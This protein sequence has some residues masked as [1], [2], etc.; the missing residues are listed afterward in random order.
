MD[1]G[2]LAWVG[3][4]AMDGDAQAWVGEEVWAGDAEAWVGEEVWAVWAGEVDFAAEIS[5]K[6]RT[7]QILSATFFNMCGRSDYRYRAHRHGV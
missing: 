3:E 6:W 4:E 1:G 7:E 2:A 5:I